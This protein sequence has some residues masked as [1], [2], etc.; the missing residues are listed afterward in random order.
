ML[1]VV[2]RT[3]RIDNNENEIKRTCT[4][5]CKFFCFYQC[6]RE[7]EIWILFCAVFIE[8]DVDDRDYYHYYY[9]SYYHYF[10]VYQNII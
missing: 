6:M 1:E 8:I 3:R 4:L 10:L 2:G 5:A 7:V 9:Y